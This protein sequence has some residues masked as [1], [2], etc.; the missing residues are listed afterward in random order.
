MSNVVESNEPQVARGPLILAHLVHDEMQCL[1][2]Q[3]LPGNFWLRS[4]QFP[5]FLMIESESFEEVAGNWPLQAFPEARP[6]AAPNTH[7][8][9]MGR[10]GNLARVS[11]RKVTTEPNNGRCEYESHT[12]RS[13]CTPPALGI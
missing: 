10:L 7:V 6:M 5:Q 11:P 12:Q 8:H 9:V 13:A 2:Q 4:P 1:G 3:L